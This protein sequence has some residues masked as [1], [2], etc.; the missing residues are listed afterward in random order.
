MCKAANIII[1]NKGDLCAPNNEKTIIIEL[2]I[3]G[4]MSTLSAEEIAS[5]YIK[6]MIFVKMF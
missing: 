1:P 6:L 4:L 3:S 5:Q 2:P